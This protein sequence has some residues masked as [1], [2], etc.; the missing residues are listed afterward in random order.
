ML[1]NAKIELWTAYK[2]NGDGIGAV[3]F[4][5][6]KK[7]N[8]MIE[9]SDKDDKIAKIEDSKKRRQRIDEKDPIEKAANFLEEYTPSWA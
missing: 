4:D 2:N 3:E 9:E 5:N 1:G 6:N 7:I 8:E